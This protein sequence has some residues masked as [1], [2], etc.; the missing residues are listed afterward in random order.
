M[1]F[2]GVAVT[3]NGTYGTVDS[4]TVRVIRGFL[5]SYLWELFGNRKIWDE[6]RATSTIERHERSTSQQLTETDQ[7]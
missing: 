5:L 1:T 7:R 4:T 6:R 2:H 3:C